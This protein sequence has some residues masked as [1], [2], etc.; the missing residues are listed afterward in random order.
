MKEKISRTTLVV[1]VVI[2]LYSAVLGSG[3]PGS[4]VTGLCIAGV[5]T[6]PA[7]VLGPSQYRIIGIVGFL[8]LSSLALHDYS[9]GKRLR[10][11]IGQEIQKTR[12]QQSHGNQA[13]LSSQGSGRPTALWNLQT[14]A[15]VGVRSN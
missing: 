9:A 4:M 6:L 3:M 2:V 10:N 8:F 1:A 5:F 15:A 7:V 11:R 14:N 13:T 12:G